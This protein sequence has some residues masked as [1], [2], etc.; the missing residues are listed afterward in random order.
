MN[1]EIK[2]LLKKSLL[3]I[4]SEDFAD[5]MMQKIHEEAQKPPQPG[6]GIIW[7]WLFMSLAALILP[8]GLMFLFSFLSI[9]DPYMKQYFQ[10][11]SGKVFLQLSVTIALTL[12]LLFQLDNLLRMTFGNKY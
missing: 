11:F 3:K 9:Y 1:D 6:R 10:E 12:F 5:R 8:V 4:P 7:S 2:A